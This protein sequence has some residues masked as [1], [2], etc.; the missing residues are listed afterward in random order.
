MPTLQQFSAILFHIYVAHCP[1]RDGHTFHRNIFAFEKCT[2]RLGNTLIHC[3]IQG[4]YSNRPGFFFTCEK[5]LRTYLFLVTTKFCGP[6]QNA[7]DKCLKK[8][9]QRILFLSRLKCRGVM[10][11]IDA[12][13][14]RG[15]CCNSSGS[16]SSSLA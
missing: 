7:P 15:T 8:R 3:F 4:T 1:L 16:F 5:Q 14:C 12:I 13:Y 6:L 11:S 10:P 2:H 9:L